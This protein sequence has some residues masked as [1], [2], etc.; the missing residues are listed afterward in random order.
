M[1]TKNPTRL[2]RL[3]VIAQSASG[4]EPAYN[5]PKSVA[6]IE[7]GFTVEAEVFVPNPSRSV[8]NRESLKSDFYE[9]APISGDQHGQEFSVRFPINGWS[10][11]LPTTSPN[12]TTSTPSSGVLAAILGGVV[13]MD[14]DTGPG[15]VTSGAT[16]DDVPYTTGQSYKVGSAVGLY[17]GSSDYELS[18]IKDNAADTLELLCAGSIT[19]GDASSIYGS[20][21]CYTKPVDFT[22]FSMLWQSYTGNSRLK[23]TSAVPTSVSITFD[24]RSALMA[25]VTFM[26]NT[27]EDASSGASTLGE[28]NYTL[29]I[30]SPP[31][32]ANNARLIFQNS[33][34]GSAFTEMDCE[35]FTITMTQELTPVMAHGATTG[36]RDLIVQNRSQEITFSTLY[37]DKNPFD[38]TPDGKP[39]VDLSNPSTIGAIQLAVGTQPGKMMG[40][41]IPKPIMMQVPETV[42][43]NGVF[44][45][46]FM[47]KPGDYQNASSASGEAKGSNF[48]VAFV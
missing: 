42:D 46:S 26:T 13:A 6:E 23:I 34:A 18:F 10:S 15:S 25:E 17:D 40:V 3:Q 19:A 28:F 35:A 41:L 4:S 12:A 1:A 16:T 29:P 31:S 22:C 38:Q 24:P 45:S 30:I 11:S 32:G 33:S 2:G 47:L 20:V 39:F 5:N 8:F 9:L 43:L 21:T 7:A 36:V 44:A 27:V 14:P 48:R 37:G